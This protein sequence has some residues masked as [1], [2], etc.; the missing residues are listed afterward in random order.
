ME[1]TGS[2]MTP[3]I[4]FGM[5]IPQ[6]P[7]GRAGTLSSLALRAIQ[8]DES[9]LNRQVFALIALQ[10]FLPEESSVGG[11]VNLGT[12]SFNTL[13]EMLSQQLSRHIGD[14][15]SEVIS[16]VGFISSVDFQFGLT[17]QDDQINNTGTTSQLN[18]GLDQYFLKD[19]LRVHI[20]T[21]VDF[22]NN[23]NTSTNKSYIGGDFIVEYAISESGHLKVRAYNRSESNIFGP[24]I[25][26]GVGIS[27]QREFET[28]ESLFKEIG[29]EI[30]AARERKKA[31]KEK[32]LAEKEKDDKPIGN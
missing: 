25:R 20:G 22:S 19:K 30:K 8:Q 16:D 28:F 4:K 24:R 27:Y 32:R 23:N 21:N 10:Q 9:K 2:L 6:K 1:M 13:S 5:D 14:L 29:S 17:L 15:L 18:V 11:G 7:T 26:T 31:A 12:A 3:D